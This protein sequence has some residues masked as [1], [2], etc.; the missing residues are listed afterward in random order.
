LGGV[1]AMFSA[2]L[3]LFFLPFL[4]RFNS[5]S[6]KFLKLSQFFFWC[7]ISNFICL[8]F[9]GSCVVEEPFVTFG[10]LA[11]VFYFSYLLIIIPTLSFF[12]KSK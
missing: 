12:E 7:F 8:G 2:I 9:L 3:V 1:V 4:G 6:S 5:K 10:Q 11:T